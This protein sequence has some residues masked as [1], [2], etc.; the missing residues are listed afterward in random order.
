MT[1]IVELSPTADGMS[2]RQSIAAV[3]QNSEEGGPD[4]FQ[5]LKRSGH[6]FCVPDVAPDFKY[7]INALKALIGQGDIY[8]R[9]LTFSRILQLNT[10]PMTQPEVGSHVIVV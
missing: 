7:D 9:L 5:F 4:D 1:G 8:V 3:V 2:L 10:P 6:M